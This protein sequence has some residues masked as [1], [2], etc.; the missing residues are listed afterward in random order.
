MSKSTLLR[1]ERQGLVPKAPRNYNSLQVERT[2]DPQALIEIIRL[3][4][5]QIRKH[6]ER[7]PEA[8]YASHWT[9][10]LN[11]DGPFTLTTA[12]GFRITMTLRSPL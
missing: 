1:H 3:K 8:E 11:L 4:Q 2:Y 10:D 9:D 7:N 5:E 6:K 12:S